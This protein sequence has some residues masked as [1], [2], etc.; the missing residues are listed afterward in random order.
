MKFGEYQMEARRTQIVGVPGGLAIHGLGLAGEAGEVI[1]MLKKHVGHGHEL[2]RLKLQK[3]LGDVL[4]Y[5]SAIATECGIELD[6][7]AQLNIEKLK[8]RYPDGFQ[9]E[10]SINRDE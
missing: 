7:V 2:D 4:W 9:K 6:L 8:K 3:E 10:R 5:V 1:E